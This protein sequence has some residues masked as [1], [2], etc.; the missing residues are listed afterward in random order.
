MCAISITAVHAQS[1][2]DTSTYCRSVVTDTA[3]NPYVAGVLGNWR[4]RRSYTY[5]G[6]QVESDPS[7]ATNIRR[8]GVIKDFAAFWRF[9]GQALT[10]QYD[11]SRWVWN[12]EITLYHR[13]GM[14]VENRDPLGRYNAG[15]YGYN[16]TVPVAV[17]Q[18][19]RYREAA[20]EGFEDYG[21]VTR[22][23]DTG[24]AAQRHI[25][26]GAY[27]SMLD[28]VYRHSGRYSLRLAGGSNAGVALH[29]L[30]PSQ[31]QDT[32]VL[33]YVTVTDT[34]PGTGAMLQSIKA[35][36]SILLP[37]CSPFAGRKMLFSAWVREA[38]DCQCTA[39]DSNR[40]ELIFTGADSQYIALRPAGN[41]IEGWQRYEAAFDIPATDTAMILNLKATG[42]ATVYFDDLRI[43]PFNAN[44]KSFVYNPVNLRLMAE[45]DENNYATF[46]EYD[47]DGTLIRVKKET[48]R[49]VKTIK[50]TRSALLKQ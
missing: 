42:T 43:H 8:D 17:V 48:Q 19:A 13:S 28:T 25:D 9:Q 11:T 20:F 46:Y 33:R 47:D 18:N 5:Y 39:Y 30:S 3:F 38:R 27:A 1:P 35:S 7:T 12:S 14:E 31:D 21:F 2:C 44:M 22:V 50:E 41:I 29:L 49:G 37:V 23:C 10:P 16:L 32:V 34:C 6:R 4:A 24:C 36:R 26:F 15:L 40:V 45:L